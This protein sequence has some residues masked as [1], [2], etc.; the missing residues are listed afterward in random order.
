MLQGE[1]VR[2]GSDD[3][4]VLLPV[5][6][7]YGNPVGAYLRQASFHQY[8]PAG[9]GLVLAGIKDNDVS[10]A[11]IGEEVIALTGDAER[12]EVESFSRRALPLAG[13]F[14]PGQE[15]SRFN[16]FGGRRVPKPGKPSRRIVVPSRL[17]QYL[18]FRNEGEEALEVGALQRGALFERGY[19]PVQLRL[20]VH[21]P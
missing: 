2:F 10:G 21:R 20:L 9:V 8:L 18:F 19:Q 13:D 15:V 17:A 11:E 16:L 12:D 4:L 1:R 5:A 7:L 14:Q 3:V 6:Q